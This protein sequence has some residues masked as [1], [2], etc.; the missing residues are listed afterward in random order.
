MKLGIIKCDVKDCPH[1]HEEENFN[2]G[3]PGWGHVSGLFNDDTGSDEAHLCPYHME[4]IK[5]FLRGDFEN[6]VD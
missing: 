3:F 4:Y 1:R 6:G 5:R 2:Q